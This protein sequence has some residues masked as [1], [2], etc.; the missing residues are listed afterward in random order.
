MTT[1]NELYV[2]TVIWW[3]NR[4][5][6]F[7][8]T[9][10]TTTEKKAIEL[11]LDILIEYNFIDY[12]YYLNLHQDNGITDVLTENDFIKMLKEKAISIEELQHLCNNLNYSSYYYKQE[13]DFEIVKT[14][15]IK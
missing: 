10:I 3:S 8:D 11:C 5:A 7:M 9:A 4:N 15:I 13:W 2:V 6:K 12:N 1:I 14:V